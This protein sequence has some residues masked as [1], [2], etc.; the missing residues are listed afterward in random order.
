M[1]RKHQLVFEN[2]YCN[3]WVITWPSG[4]G[5]DWHGHNGSRASITILT[6]C[7]VN[8]NEGEI[9]CAYFPADSFYVNAGVKHKIQNT[10]IE[11]SAVSFHV[12]CPP[13]H[14]EY[15]PELELS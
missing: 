5:L 4:T 11:F 3:A 14:I 8:Q 7:L 2:E 1:S 15:D 13:L 12:Y 9:S 10:D 6:G